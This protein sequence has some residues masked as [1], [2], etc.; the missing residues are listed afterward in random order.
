MEREM[1]TERFPW[2]L[3]GNGFLVDFNT[4]SEDFARSMADNLGIEG[5]LTDEHWRIL[6]Y[7]RTFFESTK[8]CPLVF[9][10]CR[11]NQLRL[12]DLKRL[13][14]QGYLR[15]ACRLAGLSYTSG[16]PSYAVL[17]QYVD[18]LDESDLVLAGYPTD[19]Y[20]F[21]VD[22]EKWERPFAAAL[23]KKLGYRDELNDRHWKVLFYLREMFCEDRVVPTIIQTCEDLR[24][25]L[26]ELEDLF[27]T[28]Y[29]RGA[30]RMAGLRPAT[31]RS[32]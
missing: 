29:N 31:R 14:P 25:E 5:G 20:G 13:F 1:E 15:G 27:P 28:G 19:E 22:P 18:D 12:R 21:L 23:A 24:V 26:D 16:Y 30:V 3:D 17:T 11:A 8:R 9:Q 32:M 2:T 10:T 7:I 6:Y 4:W